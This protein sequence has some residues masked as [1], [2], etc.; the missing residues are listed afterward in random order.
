MKVGDTVRVREGITWAGLEGKIIS[1]DVVE[2][3]NPIFIEFED[4]FGYYE[5]EELDV[6][7]AQ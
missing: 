7:S 3:I 4:G 2:G 5:D 6:I 1:I